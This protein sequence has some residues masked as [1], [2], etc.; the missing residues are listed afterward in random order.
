MRTHGFPDATP[1]RGGSDGGIDVTSTSGLAQVK[2]I[3]ADIGR[4]VLQRL[5][6]ARGRGEQQ[7]LCFSGTGFSEPA[8]AYADELSIA[9]LT[10]NPAGAVE[11]VNAAARAL[12]TQHSN[13]SAGMPRL[14]RSGERVQQPLPDGCG[15]VG[16]FLLGVILAMGAVVFIARGIETGKGNT[17]T[18][19]LTIAMAAGAALLLWPA[20]RGIIRGVRHAV[21]AMRGRRDRP[22]P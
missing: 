22:L 9:L 17:T 18:T 3:G 7:L 10:F 8:R 2:Y 20:V 12:V 5:V 21:R 14:P 11:P 16:A 6:G 1:T 4:P 15:A 19:V 13:K